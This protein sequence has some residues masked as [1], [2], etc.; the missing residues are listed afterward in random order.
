MKIKFI[1]INA[2]AGT[3]PATQQKAFYKYW[4]FL[5]ALLL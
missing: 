2:G 1:L 4:L 3:V 5:F